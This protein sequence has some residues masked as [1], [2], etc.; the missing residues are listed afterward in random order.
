[1]AAPAQPTTSVR[2]GIATA[3]GRGPA[4]ETIKRANG[5][6]VPLIVPIA[7]GEWGY[8]A[9]EEGTIVVPEDGRLLAFSCMAG[10]VGATVQI[11][12]GDLIPIPDSMG[13]GI[14]VEADLFNPTIKFVDT[15]TYFV[16]YVMEGQ[17]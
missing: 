4:L 16:Q 12:D 6:E 7:I 8:R 14:S 13:F 11:N 2:T 3:P 1:M 15:V 10:P 5:Y 17:A 9:G